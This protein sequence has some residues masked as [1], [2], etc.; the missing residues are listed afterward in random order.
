MADLVCERGRAMDVLLDVSQEGALQN[1]LFFVAAGADGVP[2]AVGEDIGEVKGKLGEASQARVRMADLVTYEWAFRVVEGR[3]VVGSGE[4]QRLAVDEE[5]NWWKMIGRVSEQGAPL[6][7][8]S[9]MEIGIGVFDAADGTSGIRFRLPMTYCRDPWLGDLEERL[10]VVAGRVAEERVDCDVGE[11]HVAP[12]CI[13]LS[14]EYRTRWGLAPEVLEEDTTWCRDV[15][16]QLMEALDIEFVQGKGA[17]GGEVCDRFDAARILVHAGV[18]SD[19]E[20]ARFSRA[21][22]ARGDRRDAGLVDVLESGRAVMPRV[23]AVRGDDDTVVVLGA[24]LGRHRAL[25]DAV[26]RIGEGSGRYPV[27]ID[28]S[29]LGESKA[30]DGL[31]PFRRFEDIEGLVWP[32]TQALV[33]SVLD[34]GLPAIVEGIGAGPERMAGLPGELMKKG[35]VDL[36]RE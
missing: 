7:R 24:G 35:G 5:S 10:G 8:R 1:D 23:V 13:E 25:A 22:V 33:D 16:C 4:G 14:V 3:S 21:A 26:E 32:A 17:R 20:L 15:M 11:A 12:G 18:R 34:K 31:G 27:H 29:L 36:G 30:V 9:L 2:V 19:A 28:Q 6:W